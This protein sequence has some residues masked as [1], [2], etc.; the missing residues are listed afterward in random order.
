ML[1]LW[2]FKKDIEF[3]KVIW[4]LETV[5]VSDYTLEIPLSQEQVLAL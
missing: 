4:D 2:Y 1:V 3:S 5:T